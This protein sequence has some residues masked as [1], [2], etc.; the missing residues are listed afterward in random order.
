MMQNLGKENVIGISW[1][2]KS[3][4]KFDRKAW[5]VWIIL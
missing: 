4:I 5:R 1:E 3:K 2:Y